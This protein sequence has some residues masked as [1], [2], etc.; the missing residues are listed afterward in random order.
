[1]H[2]NHNDNMTTKT[3][4]FEYIQEPLLVRADIST[5]LPPFEQSSNAGSSTTSASGHDKNNNPSSPSSPLASQRQ[6]RGAMWAGGI[7]GLVVGGPIGAGLGVWSG[8]HFSKH[9]E[10][11]VGKFCRKTGDFAT[12]LG[13]RMQREWQ[14][15]TT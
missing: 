13:R 15:S 6:V 9:G 12:R 3:E 14:N 11:Q 5:E 4:E 7:A 1:M 2:S 10:G 8:H